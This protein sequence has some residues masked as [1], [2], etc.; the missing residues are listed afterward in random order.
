MKILIEGEDYPLDTLRNLVSSK[1]YISSGSRGIIK[2]VGYY[3]SFTRNEIIYF[4][5]KV[6][7]DENKNVLFGV[8]KNDL[9]NQESSEIVDDI[10]SRPKFQYLLVLF[11]RSM[12]EYRARLQNTTLF[13]HEN[14]PLINSNIGEDES[15]YLDVILSII[16]F[17]K[18]NK[19]I[20]VFFEK[21]H[22]SKKHTKVNWSKTVQNNLPIINLSNIPIY[23]Q[24]RVKSKMV[25]VEESLLVMYYSVLN[26]LK[27]EYNFNI[28][29][30]IH[31]K[32]Y[33][34]KNYI[35]LIKKAPKILKKIK[36][37]YFSDTL[38]KIYRLMDIYFTIVN[39]TRVTNKK[40]EFI[41]VDNYHLIFED[42][43]DK[44]FSDELPEQATKLKKQ[45]DGKIVDHLFEYDSLI[46]SDE[47]IFYIGDSK[48]YKIG[49]HIETK[50]VYKQFTYA[51]NVIQFNIDL[52]NEGKSINEKLR[53]RDGL[54]EGYSLS[55]NFFIQGRVYEDM[56]F[57]APSLTLENTT[58]EHSFHFE[59]RLFDRDTLFVHYYNINFL[60]VLK[61]YISKSSFVLEQFRNDCKT[62]FKSK[63]LEYLNSKYE[64][65]IVEFESKIEIEDYVSSKFK[66]LN[67]KI[68][69]S[70]KAP[71][72][73]I[74]VQKAGS[75]EYQ[76]L[77]K[78]IKKV[79]FK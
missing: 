22:Q 41:V 21:N 59:D 65:F 49:N 27:K 68:Y 28:K 3:Y 30:D 14:T 13:Q 33:E 48:Y 77:P 72:S 57:N 42:M 37:K 47:S 9:V 66:I 23:L 55:P 69:R 34:G 45:L 1:F 10:F 29:I 63:M 26:N 12:Q 6:F 18:K 70:R 52:L 50:S 19:N 71:Q 62:I 8:N 35:K 11:Y 7:I 39:T 31:H 78:D 64:L 44:L 17:H 5:P 32:I 38:I 58:P 2:Y 74:F 56:D 53:Y 40:E 24:A 43:V 20:I 60:F 15:S 4:L 46:D 75:L 51:K 61:S 16:N 67:G 76:Y 36:Y 54:T 79:V 25:D 73:L